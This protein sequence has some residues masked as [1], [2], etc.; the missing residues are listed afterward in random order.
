MTQW[1][2]IPNFEFY[3]ASEDGEI[4]SVNRSFIT[5]DGRRVNYVGQIMKPRLNRGGYLKV[6]LSTKGAR[7]TV[8]VHRLV[9]LAFIPNPE[10]KPEIDHKNGI[11]TDNR[12]R[13]LH[14]VTSKENSN[15]PLHIANI[16][17]ENNS[18]YGK[19]HTEKTR[20]LIAESN[21]RRS[22]ANH[23]RSRPVINLDTGEQF[24]SLTEAA[25]SL[26]YS[27]KAVYQAMRRNCVCG[28]YRWKYL[29]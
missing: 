10:N 3:E 17:G 29:Q 28:G 19:K 12:V 8:T 25:K 23:S 24:C 13:N 6:I 4:R 1:R 20:R 14:W 9:T 16:S 26:G 22:G 5:K 7:K 11:R 15:M 2:K 21:S 27:T 18:F